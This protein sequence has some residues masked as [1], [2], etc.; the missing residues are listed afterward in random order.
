MV[1]VLILSCIQRQMVRD[2][3]AFRGELSRKRDQSLT[4]NSQNSS[5]HSMASSHFFCILYSVL[6][7][8][9]DHMVDGITTT[10]LGLNRP[11]ELFIQTFMIELIRWTGAVDQWSESKYQFKEMV[12]WPVYP[13]ISQLPLDLVKLFFVLWRRLKNRP[14]SQPVP[15]L[16]ARN[17]LI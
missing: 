8:Q 15:E 14:G 12:P 7:R 4:P 6:R 5:N 10:R 16:F 17:I 1:Y 9:I 13:F 11:I 3:C 2:V